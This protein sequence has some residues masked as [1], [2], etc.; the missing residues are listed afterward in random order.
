[1]INVNYKYKTERETLEEKK[2]Q[3]IKSYAGRLLEVIGDA[4]TV[5]ITLNNRDEPIIYKMGD[6]MDD[7][8]FFDPNE[9]IE[10]ADE[11][12]VGWY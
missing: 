3:D 10:L 9:P 8:L 11:R 7:A 6:R 2:E 4:R 1:M 12:K 5:I